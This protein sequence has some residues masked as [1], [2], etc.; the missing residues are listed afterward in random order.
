M[1]ETVPVCPECHGLNLQKF[2]RVRG[3]QNYRCRDCLRR[4]IRPDRTSAKSSV[5][6]FYSGSQQN[7]KKQIRRI[8]LEE[9]ARSDMSVENSSR[10]VRGILS[11]QTLA[12]DHGHLQETNN[13]IIVD[14]TWQ[15]KKAGLKES[16]IA[17]RRRGLTRLNELGAD[18]RNPETV[19]TIL[20]TENFSP[21]VHLEL[22]RNYNAFCR[23]YDIHWRKPKTTYKRP[24][25]KIPSEQDIDLL[26]AH[27]GKRTACLLQV[28]KDT[29]ARVSEAVKI[30]WKDINAEARTIMINHP[31]KGSQCRTVRVSEQCILAL[32]R[33]PHKYGEYIFSPH[34]NALRDSFNISREKLAQRFNNDNLRHIH[35]H[36]LRHWKATSLRRKKYDRAYV[37]YVLGHVNANNTAWYDHLIVTEPDEWIVLRPKTPKE[38]DEAIKND[39][40]F[41]R[42][43]EEEHC[44]IYRKRK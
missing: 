27:C 3:I 40:D 30:E 39:F 35:F 26:M 29:A 7:D 18:L 2:G 8:S 28:L 9:Y 5:R 10:M 38:E 21:C 1:V 14:F 23:M 17:N 42:Y 11:D 43:D 6:L 15:Q 44:P 31:S 25:V 22:V 19:L 4:T 16:T 34:T 13:G 41:V 20:A 36:L 37:Q 33:M 24:D 12:S 32:M